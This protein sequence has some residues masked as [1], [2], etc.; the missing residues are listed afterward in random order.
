VVRVRVEIMG[1]GTYENVGKYQSLLI[2]IGPII[3]TRTRREI[4]VESSC[5]MHAC[6][7]GLVRQAKQPAATHRHQ[8]RVGGLCLAPALSPATHAAAAAATRTGHATPH[9]AAQRRSGT[10]TAA[11]AHTHN[12]LC[13]VS[14]QQPALYTDAVCPSC[15]GARFFLLGGGGACAP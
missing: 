4:S 12:I 10:A 2:M 14:R 7:Q 13:Y 15:A 11:C 6:M 5:C 9:S 8:R 1:P 3:F